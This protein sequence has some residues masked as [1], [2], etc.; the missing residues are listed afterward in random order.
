MCAYCRAAKSPKS[1]HTNVPGNRTIFDG[2]P[3]S[4]AVGV[5]GASLPLKIRRAIVN[6]PAFSL[7][8]FDCGRVPHHLCSP[9]LSLPQAWSGLPSWWRMKDK[10]KQEGHMSGVVPS[11]EDVQWREVLKRK[12]F[13][14]EADAFAVS[15][16]GRAPPAAVPCSLTPQRPCPSHLCRRCPSAI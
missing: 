11:A 2:L 7:T 4:A 8:P 10:C 14:R 16:C 5:E 3:I 1:P 12:W 6:R 15:A 13:F 9:V